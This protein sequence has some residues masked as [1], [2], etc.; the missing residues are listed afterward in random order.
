MFLIC[1]LFSSWGLATED[2]LT[3]NL[4][5]RQSLSQSES[6]SESQSSSEPSSQSSNQPLVIK[7]EI[8]QSLLNRPGEPHR[9]EIDVPYDGE[10]EGE[11]FVFAHPQHQRTLQDIGHPVVQLRCRP[12][13]PGQPEARYHVISIDQA[14]QE[15]R[16][17][18][19]V[20]AC[21]LT[22]KIII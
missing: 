5:P 11:T 7:A 2:V 4:V 9:G 17:E 14:E 6:Q 8:P 16:G 3:I 20:V 18:P 21:F 1:F 12:L 15:I 22:N 13:D 19:R 10:L